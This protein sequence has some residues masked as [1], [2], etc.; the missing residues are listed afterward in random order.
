[1]LNAAGTDREV[2]PSLLSGASKDYPGIRGFVGSERYSS[3]EFLN[4]RG[5]KDGAMAGVARASRLLQHKMLQKSVAAHQALR[6]FSDQE[7]KRL[8]KRTGLNRELLTHR[9]KTQ[10]IKIRR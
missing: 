5:A 8:I 7:W 9:Q 10:G 3:A 1:M 2:T 6:K 4:L